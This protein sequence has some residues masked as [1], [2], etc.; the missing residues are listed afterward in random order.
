MLTPALTDTAASLA[1]IRSSGV[2][3]AL[4]PDTVLLRFT[5]AGREP[6]RGAVGSY[7]V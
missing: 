1:S 7:S 6:F 2:M 4:V 5:D 3:S